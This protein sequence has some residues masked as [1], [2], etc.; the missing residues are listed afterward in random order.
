MA[1][2]KACKRAECGKRFTP[3]PNGNRI[4]LPYCSPACYYADQKKKAK[5][6]TAV[7]KVSASRERENPIYKEK[8]LAFLALPENHFCFING[9]NR[10]ATT[11]EHLKGRKGYADDWARDNKI[12]L[13]IDDRFWAP[14]CFQHNGELENNTELSRAYQLSKIHDGKKGAGKE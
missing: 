9:C 8:R 3:K 10:R 2:D 1:K 6:R 11:I 14:C 5:P 13:Y 4:A 7:K 12:S